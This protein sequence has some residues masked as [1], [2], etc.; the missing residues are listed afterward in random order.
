M[1]HQSAPTETNSNPYTLLD[2]QGDERT[3]TNSD[4]T[5]TGTI[6]YDAFGNTVGSTGSSGSSYKYGATSGYQDNGDAGLSFVAARYF[7]AAVGRFTT[8]DTYL[9]QKPYLYCEHDPVNLIDPSGHDWKWVSWIIERVGAIL[10]PIAPITSHPVVRVTITYGKIFGIFYGA[11]K[12]LD[13]FFQKPNP[14][15][16]PGGGMQSGRGKAG[17][18]NDFNAISDRMIDH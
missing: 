7:D 9:S 5:V 14:K 3:V 13:S 10:K 6:N 17:S 11:M 15:I 18:G 8:R 4:Q 2:G 12:A 1:L 16:P